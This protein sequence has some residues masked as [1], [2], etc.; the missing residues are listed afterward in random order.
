M[1]CLAALLCAVCVAGA[2]AAQTNP[3]TDDPA[4]GAALKKIDPDFGDLAVRMAG[5]VWGRPGLSNRERA[6]VAIGYDVCNQTLD[7]PF[8]FH[9]EMALKNG[10]TR[11]DVKEAVLHNVIYSNFPKTLQ[12]IERLN[13]L[14][15]RFDKQKKYRTGERVS[16]P[17]V[18]ADNFV[19]APAVKDALLGLDPKFGD[20]A[21]RMA[22]EVWGRPGLSQ[23]E[24][25]FVSLATDVCNKNL[26]GPLQFHLD[27][28]EK[29]GA[30]RD[31]IM[32]VVLTG[33]IYG[34]FPKVLEA[35]VATKAH[36]AQRDP[37]A[38]AKQ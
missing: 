2:R 14:Y 16:F 8:Q 33:V 1:R 38:P 11:R 17:A 23:K 19:A 4:V 25:A 28:A 24:R 35:V 21:A 3:V 26:A 30:S 37:P 10:A 36:F 7:G 22:G 6:L 27:M 20:L 13:R 5:E 34:A 12:A 18:G 32:E 29:G 9:V 15:A 31:E